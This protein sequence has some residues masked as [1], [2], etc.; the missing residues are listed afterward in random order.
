MQLVKKRT[1]IKKILLDT[2]MDE[3]T[4]AT[5]CINKWCFKGIETLE[6][7]IVSIASMRIIKKL[8]SNYKGKLKKTSSSNI[9]TQNGF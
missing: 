4:F 1:H 8:Y 3:A 2:H 9:N 5:L 6:T 7:T